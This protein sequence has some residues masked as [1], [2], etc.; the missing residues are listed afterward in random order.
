MARTF[1]NLLLTA[2]CSFALIRC[3]G[4]GVS[5]E[6]SCA[7]CGPMSDLSGSITGQ[8]G[9]QA[10]M[11][12]WVLVLTEK[13]TGVS[14]VAEVNTSGLFSFRNARTTVD[15]TLSLLSPDYIL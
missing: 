10:Q 9:T 15:H 1:N 11:Q 3:G 2:A 4:T 8:F 5:E 12:G 6:E 14:R 7:L 13:S